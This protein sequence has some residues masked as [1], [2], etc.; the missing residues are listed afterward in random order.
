MDYAYTLQGWL[1]GVNPAMGGTLTNG[2][3]TT[4]AFPTTQDAYGFSLHYYRGDYKTI[5]CVIMTL[6]SKRPDQALLFA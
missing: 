5:A 4:E 2:T 1:K 3:D 6:V